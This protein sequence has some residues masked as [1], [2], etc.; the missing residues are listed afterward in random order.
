MEESNGSGIKLKVQALRPA[1]FFHSHT[2]PNML[3]LAVFVV[4][5]C[6]ISSND[7]L[8]RA[9]RAGVLLF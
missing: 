7:G 3:E 4:C 5:E 6:K 2:D 1:P 9:K 8:A